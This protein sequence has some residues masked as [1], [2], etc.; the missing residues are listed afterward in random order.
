MRDH[1]VK[2]RHGHYHASFGAYKL[3]VPIFAW[4]GRTEAEAK[5]ENLSSCIACL[6]RL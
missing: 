2:V 5:A 1:D 3:S 4:L 6:K